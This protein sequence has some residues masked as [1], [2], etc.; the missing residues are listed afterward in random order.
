MGNRHLNLFHPY[1]QNSTSPIENNL[2]RGLAI[3]LQEYPAVMMLFLEKLKSEYKAHQLNQQPAKTDLDISFPTQ[4]YDIDIQKRAV[5]FERTENI[6]GVSLT[7]DKSNQ[8]HNSTSSGTEDPIPDIAISYDDTLIFIEVKCDNT[9]CIPQLKN[10]IEKYI[11][12]NESDWA[13]HPDIVAISWSDVIEVLEQY[14]SLNSQRTD[15][16]ISDYLDEISINFPTWLPIK[17]LNQLNIN[18]VNNIYARLTV[19]KNIYLNT[20][21]QNKQLQ[22]DRGAI[23]LDWKYASECNIFLYDNFEDENEIKKT[24]LVIGVW[25]SDTCSQFRALTSKTNFQFAN[26]CYSTINISNYGKLKTR[27]KPYI[28]MCHYNRK[29][30]SIQTDHITANSN[31]IS[32]WIKLA[33][34]ITGRTQRGQWDDLL[35]QIENS[36]IFADATIEELKKEFNSKFVNAKKT[37]VVCSIGFE[38]CAY[39]DFEEAQKIEANL[40]EISLC[41]IIDE[42]LTETRKLIES[43]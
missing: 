37:Y 26:Q 17:P 20:K 32:E 7:V 23:P 14:N 10:Q 11:N 21:Q 24:Y 40:Y 15:K 33:N 5:D 30:M 16:L 43:K 29:V 2:S 1:T 12:S 34:Q 36:K 42:F 18:N 9:N 39:F 8:D 28:K 41:D 6:I 27:I 38:I 22:Y 13:L 4:T 19:I 35:V 25:P 31:N 3:I